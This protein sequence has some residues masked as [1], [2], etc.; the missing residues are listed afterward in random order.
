MTK[1]ETKPFD[2]GTLD[3]QF[4]KICEAMEVENRRAGNPLGIPA[5]FYKAFGITGKPIGLGFYCPNCKL[6]I[7]GDAEKKPGGIVHCGRVDRFPVGLPAFL[8]RL[9]LKTHKMPRM[10]LSWL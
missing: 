1:L 3:Q 6:N 5:G 10:K 7:P 4:A 2:H 9:G 8:K